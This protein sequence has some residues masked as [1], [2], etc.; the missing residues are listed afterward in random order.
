[1]WS[2]ATV[3]IRNE[4]EAVMVKLVIVTREQQER[5][6]AEMERFEARIHKPRRRRRR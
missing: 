4:K 3:L 1:M 6:R 2:G 5:G